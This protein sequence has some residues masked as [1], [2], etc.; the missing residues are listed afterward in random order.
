MLPDLTAVLV[1]AER[2]AGSAMSGRPN[3][4]DWSGRLIDVRWHD[5][6]T[7]FRFPFSEITAA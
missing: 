2:R 4:L 3:I 6:I 5:D 1:K 7:M